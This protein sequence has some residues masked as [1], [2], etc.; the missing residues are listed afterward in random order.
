M[1]INPTPYRLAVFDMAGT[2]VTDRHEVEAA[3]KKACL[4]SGLADV[5]DARIR[6]LQG[7]SKKAVF[8]LLW[9]ERHKDEAEAV[10]SAA[11]TSYECFKE[12]LEA[13]YA[14][15]PVTPTEGAE[16]CFAFLRDRGIQIA[17]TTGFYRRV[18]DLLL[19]QLGWLDGLDERRIGTGEDRIID[20][21]VSGEEV[22]EGRPA[23]DMIFRSMAVLGV[24]DAAQVLNFGDT[25]VDIQS[26]RN[27]ACGQVIALTN[28]TH[29]REEL[30]GKGADVLLPT[31]ADFPAL[32]KTWES[33]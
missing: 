33:A 30:E 15:H 23:P 17:L 25:P 5:S 7:Y 21:S 29:T 28:G 27:A 18:T 1:L 22:P 14:A 13:H 16:A 6:A 11:T 31:L 3:F 9:S 8:R 12:V 19:D 26:G 32:F 2:T 10:E 24:E 20:F 4:A